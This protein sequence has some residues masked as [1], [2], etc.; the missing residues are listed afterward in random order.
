MS[1]GNFLGNTDFVFLD[2]KNVIFVRCQC[3]L[4]KIVQFIHNAGLQLEYEYYK[5]S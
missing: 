4:Y 2:G 3:A 5:V 1:S